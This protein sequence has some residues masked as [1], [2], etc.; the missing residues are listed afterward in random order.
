M[1]GRDINPRLMR[2][3]KENLFSSLRNS[4]LSPEKRCGK[5][6]PNGCA[7]CQ[8]DGPQLSEKLPDVGRDGAPVLGAHPAH[9]HRDPFNGPHAEQVH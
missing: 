2:V 8:R 5:D 3:E 7:K 9:L 6:G 1:G 4:F